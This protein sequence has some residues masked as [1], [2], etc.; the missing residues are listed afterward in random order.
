[1]V[2]EISRQ[3]KMSHVSPKGLVKQNTWGLFLT[4][5]LF[6]GIQGAH[7]LTGKVEAERQPH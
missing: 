6:Q 4:D 2:K 5:R 7:W 1:M 3:I